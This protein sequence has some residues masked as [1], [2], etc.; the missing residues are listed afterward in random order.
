MEHATTHRITQVPLCLS[1]VTFSSFQKAQSFGF[2]VFMGSQFTYRLVHIL[3][4]KF[5]MTAVEVRH[6]VPSLR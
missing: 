4:L 1:Q 3:V 2:P 5:P 6:N